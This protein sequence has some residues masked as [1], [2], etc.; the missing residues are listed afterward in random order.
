MHVFLDVHVANNDQQSVVPFCIASSHEDLQE[1]KSI[2][3]CADPNS[4]SVVPSTV[5]QRKESML[6]IPINNHGSFSSINS[7]SDLRLLG[8]KLFHP[9]ILKYGQIHHNLRINFGIHHAVLHEFLI[10][11]AVLHEFLIHHAVLNQFFIQ[12]AVRDLFFLRRD[13]LVTFP[14][15]PTFLIRR[16]LL[17][18]CPPFV[19]RKRWD[20]SCSQPTHSIHFS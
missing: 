19:P 6:G 4:Q 15:F 8:C 1:V 17:I 16:D 10:H 14:S 9:P 18:N 12:H 11:N 20:M 3:S 7:S 13:L 2:S 5:S